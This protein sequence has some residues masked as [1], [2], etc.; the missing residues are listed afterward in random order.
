VL[1]AQALVER[2]SSVREKSPDPKS[3]I[4]TAGKK[5]QKNLRRTSEEPHKRSFSTHRRSA[6]QR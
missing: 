3:R 5:A 2:M 6:S 1:A 4:A